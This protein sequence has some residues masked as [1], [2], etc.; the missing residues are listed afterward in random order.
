M[1]EG[2]T[3]RLQPFARPRFDEVRGQW[4]I[5]APERVLVLDDTAKAIVDALDGRTLK[6][7]IDGLAVQYDAPRDA[8]AA[9]VLSFVSELNDKRLV[10]HG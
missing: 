2:D 5:N 9:D 8:I 10:R 6:D 7:I 4:I 3:V 1:K